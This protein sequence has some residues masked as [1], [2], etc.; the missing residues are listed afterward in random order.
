MIRHSLDST[1]HIPVYTVYRVV[2][3]FFVQPNCRQ[4]GSVLHVHCTNAHAPVTYL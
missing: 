3:G 2:F 1:E 4:M